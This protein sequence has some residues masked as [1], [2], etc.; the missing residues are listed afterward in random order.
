LPSDAVSASRHL[1]RSNPSSIS[2]T[3]LASISPA[4]AAAAGA[5]V[6]AAPPPPPLAAAP[7]PPAAPPPLAPAAPAAA[8]SGSPIALA[9]EGSSDSPRKGIDLPMVSILRRLSSR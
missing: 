2:L 3:T 7:A 6:A 1:A 8:S 9:N 5:G 4:G